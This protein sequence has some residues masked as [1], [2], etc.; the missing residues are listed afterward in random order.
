MLDVAA[1]RG[2]PAPAPRARRAGVARPA[3]P[4]K[5]VWKKSENG[6]VVAEHL[7]HLLLGHR[8][9]AAAGAPPPTCTFQPPGCAGA[10]RRAACSYIRQLAPSSSYF[11]PLLGIAE[12]LVGFVDLLELRFGGLVAR[13]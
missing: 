7:P 4:P 5:N 1:L 8:A 3:A 11:L 2:A 10:R 13:D 9:E 6:I 12:H